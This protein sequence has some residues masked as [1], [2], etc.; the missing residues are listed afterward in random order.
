MFPQN[1]VSWHKFLYKLLNPKKYVLCPGSLLMQKYNRMGK[2]SRV[3]LHSFPRQIFTYN[4]EKFHI[5]Q[6]VHQ[7]S[8]L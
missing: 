4:R 2:N 6:N 5:S 1:L 7:L 8:D 3:Y